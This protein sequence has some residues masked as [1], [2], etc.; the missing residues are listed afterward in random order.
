MV[1]E[2]VVKC[3][4]NFMVLDFS[5]NPNLFL[6][7]CTERNVFVGLSNSLCLFVT[8][9]SLVLA[10]LMMHKTSTENESIDGLLKYSPLCGL[11]L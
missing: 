3:S 10:S 1:P 2:L 11:V 5:Y 6:V 7:L 4:R 8:I 9:R